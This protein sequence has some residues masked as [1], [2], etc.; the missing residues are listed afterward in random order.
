MS[1]PARSRKYKS[2]ASTPQAKEERSCRP[3]SGST[4]NPLESAAIQPPSIL[5]Y[6]CAA[7]RR[8]WVGGRGLRSASAKAALSSAFSLM[9]STCSMVRKAASCALDT[10]KSVRDLP[11]KAAARSNSDFWSA[12][13]RASSRALFLDARW[14]ITIPYGNLPDNASIAHFAL[15]GSAD[16]GT[17]TA[18]RIGPWPAPWIRIAQPR[19]SAMP[20]ARSSR[21][22][23]ARPSQL[24]SFR[25]SRTML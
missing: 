15:P 25:S 6:R 13:M 1:W 9:R 2:S 20:S 24:A 11:C 17:A 21:R 8:R 3:P 5:R 23:C 12:L 18:A 7:R 10:R 22:R 16:P 19:P 4:A 14:L